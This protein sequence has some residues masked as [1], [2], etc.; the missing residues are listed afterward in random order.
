MPSMTKP[1]LR[2][3]SGS[4]AALSPGVCSAPGSF[5]TS[6]LEALSGVFLL[7]PQPAKIAQTRVNAR[8]M[9]SSFFIVRLLLLLLNILSNTM[10]C[11]SPEIK[12]D[13]H[14]GVARTTVKTY[15]DQHDDALGNILRV[16]TKAYQLHAVR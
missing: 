7:L 11:P 13:C 5:W 2:F 16:D 14:G 12:S 10:Y 1:T 4:G 6:G 9:Q 8:I 3:F 15:G